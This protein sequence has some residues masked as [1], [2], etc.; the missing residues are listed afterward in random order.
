M[1]W[2]KGFEPSTS[3][4]TIW[5]PNQLGHTHQGASKYYTHF[6]N[7]CNPLFETFF[8]KVLRA[9]FASSSLG[10]QPCSPAFGTAH[11][12]ARLRSTAH[13]ASPSFADGRARRER[14][15]LFTRSW[16]G[17]PVSAPQLF[18]PQECIATIQAF[19]PY[20]EGTPRSRPRRKTVIDGP[21]L[22]AKKRTQPHGNT[23][24]HRNRVLVAFGIFSRSWGPYRYAQIDC[25][26]LCRCTTVHIPLT[27]QH[28]PFGLQY[29]H[30]R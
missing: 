13:E 30:S 4:A 27:I 2:V 3:R 15:P 20:G 19:P 16:Q 5:R 14:A 10:K 6:Q 28:L 9:V 24:I 17:N 23:D 8:E 29:S 7:L 22:A 12:Y 1:G 11:R 25:R 18:A 26:F 21:F